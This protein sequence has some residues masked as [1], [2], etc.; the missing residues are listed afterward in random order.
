MPS[1]KTD[2]PNVG[3][4][5]VPEISALGNLGNQALSGLKINV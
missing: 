1:F 4:T 2:F 3:F 5:P